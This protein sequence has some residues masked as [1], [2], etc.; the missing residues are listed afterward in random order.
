[1]REKSIFFTCNYRSPI[2]TLDEFENCCQ[3]FH[4]IL[5]KIDDTSAFCSIVIGYFVH[6]V[7]VHSNGGQELDFLTSTVGYTK[8]IDRETHFFSGGSSCIDLIVCKKPEIVTECGINHSLFQTCHHN[9]IFANI[10]AYIPISKSYS[11]ESWDYKNANVEGM[12]KS[13]SPFNWE[14]AFENLSISEKVG[15]LNNILLNVF[16]NY[17]SIKIVKCSYRGPPWMAKQIK[18]KLNNRSKVTK[19]Y[20]GK[21]KDPAIFAE[22]SRISSEF[23]DLIRKSKM[24][25]IKKKVMFFPL[26]FALP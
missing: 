24:S 20:H 15:L 23:T 9:L 26:Y 11:R 16:H 1:M 2:Q 7:H 6:F 19:H 10:S 22:L 13:I 25:Y 12:Q 3:N 17:I 8:L 18:S 5:S 21:N 14:K 4:L